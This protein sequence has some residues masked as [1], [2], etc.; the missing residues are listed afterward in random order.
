[1]TLILLLLQEYENKRAIRLFAADLLSTNKD[2]GSPECTMIRFVRGFRHTSDIHVT[3]RSQSRFYDR[4]VL[5][6]LNA[7]KVFSY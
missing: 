1:M 4:R 5:M 6:A 7:K 2:G 3:L